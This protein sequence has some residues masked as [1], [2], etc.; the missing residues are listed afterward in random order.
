MN[1]LATTGSPRPAMSG[2]Q[3]ACRFRQLVRLLA[4]CLLIGLMVLG[5]LAASAIERDYFFDRLDNERGLLQNSIQALAQTRDGT[6]WIGTQAGL[7]QFDGY[8]FKVYEHDPD[9]P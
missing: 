9:D 4:P 3:T 7:H 8:R 6:M 1:A 2:M 5:P